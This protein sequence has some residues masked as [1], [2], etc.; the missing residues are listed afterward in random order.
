MNP[1]EEVRH[2]DA[3]KTVETMERY[4]YDPAYDPLPPRTTRPNPPRQLIRTYR[5][6]FVPFDVHADKTN[7]LMDLA[8][9]AWLDSTD[10]FGDPALKPRDEKENQ[11]SDN[12]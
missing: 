12:V 8:V 7:T 9:A 6:T 11:G 10:A 3:R 1:G 4:P 2:I 5:S